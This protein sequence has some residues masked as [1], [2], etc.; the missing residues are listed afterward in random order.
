MVIAELDVGLVAADRR[1]DIVTADRE[2]VLVDAIAVA[3]AEEIAEAASRRVLEDDTLLPGD[4]VSTSRGLFRFQG[5]P[6]RERTPEDF[7]QIR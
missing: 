1:V 2:V 4:I 6:D 3:E 7:V 5:S